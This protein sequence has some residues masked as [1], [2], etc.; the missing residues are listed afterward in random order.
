MSRN[1]NAGSVP[2]ESELLEWMKIKSR[3]HG[4]DAWLSYDRTVLNESLWR[5][6]IERVDEHPFAAPFSGKVEVSEGRVWENLYSVRLGPPQISFEQSRFSSSRVTFTARAISGTQLT[7]ET[8]QGSAKYISRIG[9]YSPLQAPRLVAEAFIDDGDGAATAARQVRM[10]IT[11]CEKPQFSF[12]GPR[13]QQIEGGQFFINEVKALPE[14]SHHCRLHTLGEWEDGELVPETVTTRA[15]PI[16]DAGG[17]ATGDGAVVVMVATKDS[18]VGVHPDPEGDWMYPI[19]E[20][21]H[22]SLWIG[23]H[24]LMRKVVVG[25]IRGVTTDATFAYDDIDDPSVITVISG[26]LKPVNMQASVPPLGTLDYEVNA[27]LPG[28]APHK[29]V[30]EITRLEEGL[31]LNWKA[32]TFPLLH[33]PLL[34][35]QESEGGTALDVAWRIKSAYVYEPA[36]DGTLGL[37]EVDQGTRWSKPVYRQGGDLDPEHYQHFPAIE[38][39]IGEGI[40]S[41]ISRLEVQMLGG[42]GLGEI[43]RFRFEGVACP[44][45]TGVKLS[46]VHWPRDLVLLGTLGARVGKFVLSPTKERVL[47]GAE[48]QFSVE[49]PQD[50]LEW[51]VENVGGFEGNPGAVSPF[52]LYKAPVADQILGRV[53][54]V[55]VTAASATHSSSAW[56]EVVT[57]TITLNP[58][59]AALAAAASRVRLSA[60]S[61]GEGPIVWSLTSLSDGSL[62][63]PAPDDGAVVDPNDREYV[64]GNGSSGGYFSVDKVTARNAAGEER[65]TP[66]LIVEKN[67]YGQI[68]VVDREGLPTNQVQL[69]YDL[70]DGEEL[71]GV[72]WKLE[73]GDGSINANGLYTM[74]SESELPYAVITAQY[75]LQGIEFGNFLIL[76]IPLVDLGDLKRALI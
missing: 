48:L 71:E 43:D 6:Y 64:R 66:L 58:I 63:E 36:D 72:S 7:V 8:T 13:Q 59:V 15:L 57:E 42:N 51:S 16:L 60:G 75:T 62:T 35:S 37:H 67:R 33:A 54:L 53:M 11:A 21:H 24:C 61:L 69:Q 41:Q 49:P 10:D 38:Q 14:S 65:V 32:S 25:G 23:A 20:A 47:Q 3:T 76:P 29:E 52:G 46:T 55:R 26:G 12:P 45:G 27:I 9:E 1:T 39:K 28:N 74:G 50:N 70:G 56:V 34:K 30:L 73:I 2:S 19:P 31:A 40:S 44:G 5:D 22:A 68:V 17:N 4:W 18:G